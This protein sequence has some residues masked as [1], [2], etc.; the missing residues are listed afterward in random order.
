MGYNFLGTSNTLALL[1]IPDS[2]TRGALTNRLHFY[3]D[4]H[5]SPQRG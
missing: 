5:P 2:A 4:G 3:P 1:T